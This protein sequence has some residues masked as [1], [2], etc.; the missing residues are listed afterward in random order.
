MA[1]VE[2]PGQG[3]IFMFLR[4]LVRLSAENVSVTLPV[5]VSQFYRLESFL[6]TRWGLE[7]FQLSKL[8]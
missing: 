8:I 6:L 1:V 4:E 7:F 5:Q 2:L 3:H